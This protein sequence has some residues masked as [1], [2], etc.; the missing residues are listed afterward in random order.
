M[1]NPST[2]M[3]MQEERDGAIEDTTIF[4]TTSGAFAVDNSNSSIMCFDATKAKSTAAECVGTFT[5][6]YDG[7]T[8]ATSTEP[9]G[10]GERSSEVGTS[11]TGKAQIVVA[12]SG[13]TVTAAYNGGVAM[14]L[15]PFQDVYGSQFDTSAMVPAPDMTGMF[16]ATTG[17]LGSAG[18][19]QVT[20]SVLDNAILFHQFAYKEGGTYDYAFGGGVLDT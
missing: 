13:S 10:P 4:G 6:I 1:Q 11:V 17:T 5:V 14:E 2:Y 15:R 18:W 16:V 12:Q 19:Q 7:K 3:V 8:D 20:L 9:S